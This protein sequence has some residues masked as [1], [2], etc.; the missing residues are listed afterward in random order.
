MGESAVL[1]GRHRTR[2]LQVGRGVNVTL[3]RLTIR[4][5]SVH[6]MGGDHEGGGIWNRGVLRV[7][8][9]RIVRN[10]AVFGGG[11]S[12]YRRLTLV[13]TMVARNTASSGGGIYTAGVLTLVDT[14]ITGNAAGEHGGAAG[15]GIYNA[16]WI[17]WVNE[18]QGTSSVSG[19][20]PNQCEGTDVC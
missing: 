3:K 18:L 1:T 19:N 9:S 16:D 4:N 17:G 7:E 6:D 2:V 12:N 5:G 14:T 13:D 20:T 8:G 10:S 15:G 11:I